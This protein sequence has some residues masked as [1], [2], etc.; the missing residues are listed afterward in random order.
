MPAAAYATGPMSGEKY[1]E[2]LMTIAQAQ[3]DGDDAEDMVQ[4]LAEFVDLDPSMVQAE[5]TEILES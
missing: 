5:I 4:E 1:R 3:A 2:A